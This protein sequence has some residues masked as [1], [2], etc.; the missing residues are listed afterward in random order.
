R[1]LASLQRRTPCNC[2]PQGVEQRVPWNSPA[3][4]TTIDVLSMPRRA[5]S[6]IEKAQAPGGNRP[7]LELLSR[8]GCLRTVAFP[9]RSA[10]QNSRMPDDELAALVRAIAWELIQLGYRPAEQPGYVQQDG[11]EPVRIVADETWRAMKEL[12]AGGKP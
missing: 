12:I 10:T 9:S 6:A 1:R 8:K 3:E 7:P 11:R 5:S 2:L 4:E